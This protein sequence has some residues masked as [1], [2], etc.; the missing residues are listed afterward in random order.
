MHAPVSKI[1]LHLMSRCTLFMLC[2]YA[3]PCST[4]LSQ[5]AI[6]RPRARLVRACRHCRHTN[7]I[8]AS[9]NGALRALSTSRIEPASHA[10]RQTTEHATPCVGLRTAAAVL[11]HNPQELAA[12]EGAE[13][14]HDVGVG[15]LLLRRDVQRERVPR[16]GD[17]AASAPAASQSRAVSRHSLPPAQDMQCRSVSV[18]EGSTLQPD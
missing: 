4:R 5:G 18:H 9:D 2:R 10:T 17:N 11:H 7:A 13:V 3:R 1:L 6:Q 14:A 8:C 15:A 16:H 12:D